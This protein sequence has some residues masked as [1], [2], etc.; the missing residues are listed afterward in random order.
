MRDAVQVITHIFSRFHTFKKHCNASPSNLISPANMILGYSEVVS[1]W[2]LW[3]IRDL[4]YK[5][6]NDPQHISTIMH[7]MLSV[8]QPSYIIQL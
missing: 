6:Y 2:T 3:S 1:S 5:L 8:V 4:G 7:G